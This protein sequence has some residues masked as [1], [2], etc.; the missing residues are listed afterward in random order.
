MLTGRNI[1]IF[2]DD[3]GRYPSTIQH[4]GKVLAE[5]NQILWVGSLG[6]RKPEL[7]FYDLKRI[8]EK[9]KS[10]FRRSTKKNQR[11]NAST[12]VIEIHPVIIPFH[13]QARVYSFN[14]QVLKWK[15]KTVMNEINV[16]DPI[17]ITSSPI[18]Y[19]IIGALNET[20][21]HYLCLDDFTLFDRA[22]DSLGEKEQSLVSVTDSCFSISEGLMKTR[23]V[24]GRHNYFLPQGV[25]TEHFSP[26]NSERDPMVNGI[27]GPVIGFFGIFTTWV[28]IELIADC[29]KAYPEYNFILLGK[30]TIDLTLLTAIPNV[31]YLGSIPF[32]R[33]PY[34]ARIFDVGLIPFV[35]NDLTIACNPLKLLEYLSLGIPVVSTNLPEVKKMA[36]NVLIAETKEQ[37]IQAIRQAVNTDSEDARKN[38][39]RFAEQFSWRAITEDISAKILEIES[40]KK[41]IKSQ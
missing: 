21:S 1:I 36:S 4:I 34:F 24:K 13:D 8:I 23:R 26:S 19:G 35:V 30:T 18:V 10:I 5:S 32:E 7:S 16:H 11:Q 39:R 27:S 14:M 9:G 17:V 12:R 40:E 38:R 41:A 20:S 6:L 29:A 37:F 2:G 3:W 31:R 28:D 22:F 25:D 33:L 15:I